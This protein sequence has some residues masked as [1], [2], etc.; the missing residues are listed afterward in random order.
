ME[1]TPQK[2]GPRMLK[3]HIPHCHLFASLALMIL[4]TSTL[5][6][7]QGR[8]IPDFGPPERPLIRLIGFLEPDIPQ[9]TTDTVLTIALPGDEKRYT[10]LLKQLLI[11]AGP[12]RTPGDILD[13]VKPYSTNF[14]IR[15]PENI[16]AQI[17]NAPP[18]EQLSIL[19]QYSSADRSLMVVG[20]EKTEEPQKH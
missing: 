20:F 7:A 11:M 17:R 1:A 8:P 19:A 2:K 13:E 18:T 3:R 4:M 15:A 12:L 16:V 6:F 14:Y 5:V 9:N 10:F